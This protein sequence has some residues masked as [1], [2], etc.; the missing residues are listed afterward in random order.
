MVCRRWTDPTHCQQFRAAA[1]V[2]ARRQRRQTVAGGLYEN[3]DDF[4]TVPGVRFGSDGFVRQRT[5]EYE[6]RIDF[7]RSLSENPPP[8]EEEEQASP[9]ADCPSAALGDEPV[10][11]AA[12]GEPSR[13]S[14]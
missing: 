4:L 10:E 9:G 5:A 11:A 13:A 7:Q 3:P 6:R 1:S 14:A 2:R 8:Q 12:T